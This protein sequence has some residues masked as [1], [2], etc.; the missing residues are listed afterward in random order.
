MF[1]TGVE[2]FYIDFGNSERL[3]L[4]RVR[5]LPANVQSYPCQA[6]ACSL[7]KVRFVTVSLNVNLLLYLFVVLYTYFVNK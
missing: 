5:P 2:V 7:A 4:N 6:F 3:K 1:S